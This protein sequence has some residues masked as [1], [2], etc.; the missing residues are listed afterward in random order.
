VWWITA[1]SNSGP[2]GRTLGE[3]GDE[4]DVVDHLGGDPPADIADDHRVT[5]AQAEEVRGVDPGVEAGDHE[6]AEVGEDDG[7]LVAAGGGEG[8]VAL[9]RGLDVGRGRLVG[10]GQLKPRRADSGARAR[11]DCSRRLGAH[12]GLSPVAQGWGQLRAAAVA[13]EPSAC[14]PGASSVLTAG[15]AGSSASAITAP[16]AATPA[17]T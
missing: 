10:P 14:V 15:W 11:F 9:K 1:T 16:A 12:G 3:L 2:S 17:D 7:A 4:R 6:Q 8:A 5:E 13:V